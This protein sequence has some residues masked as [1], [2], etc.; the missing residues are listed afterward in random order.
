MT[1]K[2]I[3][4][5]N[6]LPSSGVDKISLNSATFRANLLNNP[7]TGT[8][9]VLTLQNLTLT[10]G[11]YSISLVLSG[12]GPPAWTSNVV[13]GARVQATAD[14]GNLGTGAVV[15]A[16]V[17]STTT[18]RLTSSNIMT[19]GT[20]KDFQI[21][22]LEKGTI[23]APSYYNGPL[24]IDAK[25]LALGVG[26][27]E[28]IRV[29]LLGNVGI[30]TNNPEVLLD[31]Q[32]P[33]GT[34]TTLRWLQNNV[35]NYDW[36]IPAST[37]AFRLRYGGTTDRLTLDSSGLL[38]IGTTTPGERLD[39]R[40]NIRV[41]S[42]N[43]SN[44]ITFYGVAG[45]GN[46]YWNHT[47]VGERLYSNGS[48]IAPSEFVAGQS[49]KIV[50]LGTTTDWQNVGAPVGAAV[51]TVFVATQAGV[52]NGTATGQQAD[53]SEMLLFKG[54]DPVSPTSI[55]DRIRLLSGS[56]IFE[57]LNTYTSGTFEEVGNADSTVRLVVKENNYTVP[58]AVGINTASPRANLDVNGTVA[59]G[60]APRCF[61][62]AS[63]FTSD[64]VITTN[65]ATGQYYYE[66][67]SGNFATVYLVVPINYSGG[68]CVATIAPS[69]VGA[70]STGTVTVSQN[71]SGTYATLG[72]LTAG[73]GYFVRFTATNTGTFWGLNIVFG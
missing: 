38:G 5:S 52:G 68:T 61:I 30:G 62:P 54:N 58:G 4:T 36:Y 56:L 7:Y 29:N 31:I 33:Q 13:A 70:Q 45:D 60:V 72:T 20:I 34:A 22:S 51:G 32:T 55:L 67:V 6:L 9:V 35:T 65:E 66:F 24:S 50:T 8:N 43:A 1:I 26:G 48:I 44:Y 14:S 53:L 64:S 37:D 10:N 15:I 18:I 69:A 21:V 63:A 2:S 59:G 71:P 12:T 11:V 57:A 47:Y 39:V 23:T 16:E 46:S 3:S 28:R 40:G 73:Q 42:N 49:Y 27:A 17:V 19:V 41:G 25:Q